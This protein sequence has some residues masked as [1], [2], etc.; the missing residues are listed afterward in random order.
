M[1][2][3]WLTPD[4]LY[5]IDSEN[6]VGRKAAYNEPTEFHL[7]KLEKIRKITVR[8]IQKACR[9]D[10]LRSE[11]SELRYEIMQ[12]KSERSKRRTR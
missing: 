9:T 8:D 6:K 11:R 12:G 2:K 4:N 7:K 3:F 10:Y 1:G 5:R